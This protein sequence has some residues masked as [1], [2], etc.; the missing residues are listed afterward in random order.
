MIKKHVFCLLIILLSVKVFAQQTALYTN[1]LADYN[2]AYKLYANDQY[3]LAQKLFSEILGVTE[4]ETIKSKSAYYSSV[5]AIKLNQQNADQLV[6]LFLKEYPASVHRKNAYF[7]LANYYFKNKKYS[8][9]LKWYGKIHENSL[10]ILEEESL[11][12]HKGYS[13]FMNKQYAEAK[14]AFNKLLNSEKYGPQAKYYLGYI[15]YESDNYKEANNYFEDLKNEE[16]YSDNLSYYQAD[17]NFKLGNFQKAI[18]LGLESY[19]ISR[20]YE[21]SE[22]S[23]IIG[24]SYFNLESYEEATFYLKNYKGKNGKWNNVDY[25]QLGYV[26]FK[27]Q[28]YQNAINEFN[29]IIDGNNAVAQNAFYHLANSYLKLEQKQQALNA[30]KSASEMDFSPEMKEDAFLNYAKLSYQIGNSY[31]N[32]FDVLGLFINN[33]PKNE[34]TNEIKEL[35]LDSYISSK[36]YQSAIELLENNTSFKNR[37]AYQKVTF[38]RGLELY[39][40]GKY[41]AALQVLQKSLNEPIDAVVKIRATYWMSECNYQLLNFDTSLIGFKEF[42]Q[43][44]NAIKTPEINTINYNLGYTYFKLKNYLEAINQFNQFVSYETVNLVQKRDAYVR[45]GDCYF[46]SSAY[47]PAIENYNKALEAG[48]LNQ[49]YI[50]YQKAISYGFVDK[51]FLKVE[52]LEEFYN[53]FPTSIYR[54]DALYE[55]GN[56]YVSQ[57]NYKDALSAYNTLIRSLPNSSYVSKSLLKKA[58]ILENTGKSNEAITLFK[59]V[60]NDFP[61]SQ[62]A[63]QAVSSAKIIYIEQGRV[64]E[65]ETWVRRLDFVNVEHSEIDNASY[66]AAEI[67]YLE[68]KSD[69]AIQRFEAYLLKFPEG[70]HTLKTHFYLAQLYGAKQNSE[71]AILHYDYVLDGTRNEFTEPTLAKISQVYLEQKDYQ[72][73]LSY[74]LR[75]ETEADFLQNIIFAQSNIMKAYFELKKYDEAVIFAKKVLLND[76]IENSIKNDAQ[77]MIARSAMKTGDKE[78]AKDA[79]SEVLKTATGRVAAEA[80]Y[81]DAFFKYQAQEYE[82]SNASIQLLAKE[83]SSFKYFGAKGLLLMAKNFYQLN[84]AFQATYI[85]ES[86]IKNFKEYPEIIEE[87]STELTLIK[88]EESKTN[89]SIHV[90]EKN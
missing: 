31:Q 16:R 60:A 76:K 58:L 14:I 2:T 30:F 11:S 90:E 7:N 24:E 25:Y 18:D 37:S 5:S 21:K 70:E 73:S 19:K 23:K 63:I 17:M 50:H 77:I 53:K 89:E 6:K 71:K 64:N 20:P 32:V 87:A 55:L 62:E 46:V 79:Y 41:K 51:V 38:F 66:K 13:F 28:D 57:E 47:W 42:L 84:D 68:N 75:L 74:L 49:D 65:Y 4:N 10:T 9:A 8:E 85:L 67:S 45:L 61:S 69:Q 36:N 88:K 39:N 52:G 72:S 81:Y 43:S 26:Y 48:S 22:L 34:Q 80:S 35:L 54:D 78:L 56:T 29:K 40:E 83:Y 59:R 15:A 86:V 3:L 44:P 27:Q 33:Y 1:E 12:F 82:S